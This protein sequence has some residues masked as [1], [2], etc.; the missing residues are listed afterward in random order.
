MKI[1]SNS[2]GTYSAILI[3]VSVLAMKIHAIG[4]KHITTQ[5][6]HLEQILKLETIV[7]YILTQVISNT[8]CILSNMTSVIQYL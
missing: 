8:I 2:R 6:V 4:L 7:E 3:H 1:P 5:N